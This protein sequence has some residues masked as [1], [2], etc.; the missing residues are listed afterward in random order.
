MNLF[1]KILNQPLA[2]NS[3]IL[4]NQLLQHI[5]LLQQL[6]QQQHILIGGQMPKNNN[7]ALQL[8]VQI[9]KTK[10]NIASLQ[11]NGQIF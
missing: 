3:L 10:Q 5:K 4:L 7:A 9:T 6:N 11:V 2:P 1:F 8:S